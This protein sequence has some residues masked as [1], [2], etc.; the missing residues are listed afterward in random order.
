MRLLLFWSLERLITGPFMITSGG[1][2]LYL[3]RGRKKEDFVRLEQ[4]RNSLAQRTS[5][6]FPIGYVESQLLPVMKV[7][8]DVEFDK[9]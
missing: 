7:E 2:V 3:V 8:S 6:D 4:K 5:F 9:P 1:F